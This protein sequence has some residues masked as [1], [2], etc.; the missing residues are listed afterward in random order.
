M[1]TK[2]ET[3]KFTGLLPMYFNK[4][5]IIILSV[6]VLC[7]IG[8][9]IFEKSVPVPKEIIATI[10]FDG[11][12]V[13]LLAITLSKSKIEDERIVLIRM[14][15]FAK[16]FIFSVLYVV[17][18]SLITII[19]KNDIGFNPLSL[20]IVQLVMVIFFFNYDKRNM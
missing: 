12:I 2:H 10:A 11:I 18:I 14:N 5:G 15:A 9:M 16:A 20:I 6:S 13:G 17:V 7:I 19:M 4:I 1:K 3:N 8:G